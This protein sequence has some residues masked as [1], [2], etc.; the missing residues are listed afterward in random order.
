MF[1]GGEAAHDDSASEMLRRLPLLQAFKKWRVMPDMLLPRTTMIRLANPPYLPRPLHAVG[2]QL[3]KPDFAAH[4]GAG[5][6]KEFQ[7][8]LTTE[9]VVTL[10][11]A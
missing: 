11:T 6:Q 3:W 7:V 4:H 10:L 8:V 9:K 2:H 1:G 5:L